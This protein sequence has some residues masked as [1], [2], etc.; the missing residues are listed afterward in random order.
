[1]DT[2]A[3]KCQKK[4]TQLVWPLLREVSL[5]IFFGIT[6]NEFSSHFST[7]RPIVPHPPDCG[8]MHGPWQAIGVVM[9]CFFNGVSVIPPTHIMGLLNSHVYIY[10][11]NI[12]DDIQHALMYTTGH[13]HKSGMDDPQKMHLGNASVFLQ[14][15]IEAIWKE[16]PG[17]NPLTYQSCG[18]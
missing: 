6:M 14:E 18:I 11:C 1:M 13:N 2:D 12:S 17:L 7:I 10:R 8:S 4:K 16:I 5:P 9:V 3:K 15:C